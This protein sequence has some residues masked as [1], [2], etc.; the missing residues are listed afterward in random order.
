METIEIERN[1]EIITAQ[2]LTREPVK[3]T[4]KTVCIECGREVDWSSDHCKCGVK[5]STF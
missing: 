3:K 5:L 1:G 2:V 4:T